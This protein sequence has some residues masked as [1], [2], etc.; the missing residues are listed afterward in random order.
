MREHA[1]NQIKG[2]SSV[3]MDTYVRIPPLFIL[4]YRVISERTLQ[5]GTKNYSVMALTSI[6]PEII[7]SHH[8][9]GVLLGVCVAETNY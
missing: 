7:K 1:L 8:V 5:H 6:L 3:E 2:Q 9:T 4:L